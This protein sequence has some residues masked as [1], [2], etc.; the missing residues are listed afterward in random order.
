M[1]LKIFVGL[2]A[3][4][5]TEVG[6]VQQFVTDGTNTV[7]VT[8]MPITS[9]GST[10]QYS[11]TMKNQYNGGFTK[12]GSDIILDTS[13]VAGLQGCIPN[14]RYYNLA[15]Y[16]QSIVEGNSNPRV[17]E[18]TF[19]VGDVDDISQ[20][21]Y[22]PASGAPGIALTFVNLI[23]GIGAALSTV[24]LACTDGAGTALTYAGTGQTVYIP[25]FS[26]FGLVAASANQGTNSIT[27]GAA[28]TFIP[29]RW[30]KF[31]SGE[32]TQEI[33]QVSSISNWTLTFASSFNY[34]H[35]VNETIYDCLQQMKGKFNVPENFT[36]GVATNILNIA[37]K[38][39]A[40][41]SQRN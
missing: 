34:P 17:N 7:P 20:F 2:P 1:A 41:K 27:C 22:L 30:V 18:E 15:A 38:V 36:G 5:G 3:N 16:D 37:L 31:N 32:V 24:S 28:S 29:G 12:S 40:A 6:P 23:T 33:I 13:P 14:S 11:S 10:I 26:A 4:T 21:Q 8:D 9:V 19:Y 25:S 35:Y 39:R